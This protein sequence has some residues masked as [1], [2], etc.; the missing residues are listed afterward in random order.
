MSRIIR[1]IGLG[2]ALFLAHT[3]WQS[4]RRSQR[5]ALLPN[6]FHQPAPHPWQRQEIEALALELNDPHTS[7]QFRFSAEKLQAR[8]NQQQEALLW[9]ITEQGDLAISHPNGYYTEWRK[10]RLSHHHLEIE[11][12]NGNIQYYLIQS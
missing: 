10:R 11:L 5:Q 3:A 1:L 7:A 12:P 2:S 8:I 4:E 6:R 9:H